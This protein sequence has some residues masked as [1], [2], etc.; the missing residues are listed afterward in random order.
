MEEGE[1]DDHEG[2]GLITSR[3]PWQPGTLMSK[4]SRTVLGGEEAARNVGPSMKKDTLECV[5]PSVT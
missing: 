4:I 3:K 2:P 5:V 1:E